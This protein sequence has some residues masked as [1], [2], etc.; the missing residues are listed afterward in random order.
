MSILPEHYPFQLK[1]LPYPY[2]ALEPHID[3]ET[4]TIHH[5]KHLKAYVDNLNKALAPYP[6]YH[7]WPLEKLLCN[8]LLLP[9]SIQTAVKNNAGGV[10][11]HNL[12]FYGMS[13]TKNQQ[14]Q[15]ELR[16]LLVNTFGS[17]EKWQSLFRE[18]ALAVFGS[19]WTWLVLDQLGNLKIAN[20][21]NQD[22]PLPRGLCPVLLVDVWEHAY[23]LKYQNRRG[24]YLDNWFPLIDWH[25]AE[26]NYRRCITEKHHRAQLY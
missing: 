11:N 9:K 13:G 21:A 16:D 24:N 5:D 14:P 1:P 19:G 12:Y 4:V 3:T 6:D 26:K 2:D 10:Y 7:N 20:T 25:Q 8:L 23:Y 17:Y 15:G 18:A 22:T